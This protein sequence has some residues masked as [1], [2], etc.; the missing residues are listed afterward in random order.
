MGWTAPRRHQCA[1]MV[2]VTTHL[3]EAVHGQV[4]QESVV[5]H[6]RRARSSPRMF[7]RFMA[8][9]RQGAVVVAKPVRRGQL[10]N[11][12]AS[13]PRCLVGMEA[14]SS[15]HHWARALMR[16]GH[17]V[18]L[19][20][21]AYVKPYVR[22]NKNDAVDA[23]AICEAVGRPDMRFVAVR[24]IENQAAADAPSRARTSGGQ[25]HA[26]AQRAAR[27]FGGDRRRGGAR[28]AARLWAQAPRRRRLRRQ[29]RSRRPRLRAPSPGA[30]G[31]SDRRD[32]RRIAPSTKRSRRW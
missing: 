13:L 21:P 15:A 20:P 2:V 9:T 8:S 7:F 24:S 32:R 3:R 26:D 5:C 6:G 19:I 22:R 27:P 28:G 10:L 1:K 23:A 18:K 29:R 30:A 31:S 25:S 11:F 17:E 16:L 14:C 12:F 4:Y